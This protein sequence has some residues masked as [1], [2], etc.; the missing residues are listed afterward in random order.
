MPLPNSSASLHDSNICP[1]C[2]AGGLSVCQHAGQNRPLKPPD[3]KPD[4]DP[5]VSAAL[6]KAVLL[7]AV[8]AI[9]YFTWHS[10]KARVGESDTLADPQA[11]FDEWEPNQ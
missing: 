7:G 5:A 4:L 9:V 8:G 3:P 6:L 2:Q 10:K 1:Q 11:P